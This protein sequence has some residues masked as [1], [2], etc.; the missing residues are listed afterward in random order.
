MNFERQISYSR[1]K[2]NSLQDRSLIDLFEKIFLEDRS[3]RD[4]S[5]KRSI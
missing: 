4:L 3:L 2:K 1:L 5:L